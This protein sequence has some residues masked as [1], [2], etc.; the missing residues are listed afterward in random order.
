M[1][2]SDLPGNLLPACAACN[3]LKGEHKDHLN[4]LLSIVVVGR[5]LI[6]SDAKE[7]RRALRLARKFVNEKRSQRQAELRSFRDD[8]EKRRA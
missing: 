6:L 5:S 7:F 8:V 3:G 1:K 2:G 4:G